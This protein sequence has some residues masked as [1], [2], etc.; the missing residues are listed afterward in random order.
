MRSS[1]RAASRRR[2][3]GRPVWFPA[4]RRRLAIAGRRLACSGGPTTASC[5]CPTAAA[6]SRCA[7]GGRR[8]RA[9]RGI[10]AGEWSRESA[11]VGQS[12]STASSELRVTDRRDPCPTGARRSVR[13][14]RRDGPRRPCRSSISERSPGRRTSTRRTRLLF[15]FLGS[16]S[17]SPATTR[18]EASSCSAFSLLFF[19][20]RLRPVHWWI[21]SSCRH[22]PVS[23]WP[24][25]RC[26]LP[27]SDLPA[28]RSSTLPG[29]TSG[30]SIAAAVEE[31][32]QEFSRRSPRCLSDLCDPPLWFL[33]DV[34]RQGAASG[35]DPVGAPLYSGSAR[36]YLVLV[37]ISLAPPA[38]TLGPALETPASRL[39]R[40]SWARAL[41]A[42]GHRLPRRSQRRLLFLRDRPVI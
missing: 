7:R 33:Y 22:R 37:L 15:L 41:R 11:T 35:G 21:N 12:S 17:S 39:R 19:L 3:Q 8:S 26:F 6:A 27:S 13:R 29:R 25:P 20:C 32:L 1:H 38:F 30:M 40:T 24:C 9:A 2:R 23:L 4:R 16:S 28:P 42:A 31:K 36:R 18:R 5:P 14:G 10:L 34:F